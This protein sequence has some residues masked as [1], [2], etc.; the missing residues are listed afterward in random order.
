MQLQLALAFALFT[1]T[2]ADSSLS[3]LD[4]LKASNATLFAQFLQANPSILATYNSSS[5]QTVF[6]PSDAYFGSQSAIR[7]RD[8]PPQ[9]QQQLQY[10]YTNDLTNL[11]D[12][13]PPSSPGKVVHMGLNSPQVAG[14][15]QATVS[16]KLPAQNSTTRRRQNT[17]TVPSTGVQM[18]SGLGNS[19]NILK[20][21]IPYSN[22]VI[23]TLDG[24]FTLPTALSST[25]NSTGLSS[26][27][28]LLSQAN[29]TS[30]F[31]ASESITI[32]TP[33]NAAFAAAA[34]STANPSTLPN[35]LSNHV[36]P[37]FLGYLPSLV[38]GATYNT[39]AGDALTVTIKNG[40]YY[41]NDAKIVSS[42]TILSNGVAHV[43]DKVLVPSPS[44]V[45]TTSDRTL[46]NCYEQQGLK[47]LMH[48]A[49]TDRYIYISDSAKLDPAPVAFSD[50]SSFNPD[51]DIPI[52]TLGSDSYQYGPSFLKIAAAYEG[53]VV[54][55]LNRGANNLTNTIEAAKAAKA[56][57]PNL[58][59]I[60]L[61]NE[62]YIP[63][64]IS[65]PTNGTPTTLL[66]HTIVFAY[67]SF[68][69]APNTSTWT[70]LDEATSEST[71]QISIGTALNTSSLI[72][73]GNF[74]LPPSYGS[75]A[76]QLFSNENPAAIK[77]IRDF[78]HHNYP[79]AMDNTSTVPSPNLTTLMSH[80][81][82]VQ[83]VNLY[84]ADIEVTQKLGMEYV[85][86]ET[87]SV[88]GGGSPLISKTFGAALWVL[89]YTLRAT[90]TNI[91]HAHFHHGI[92]ESSFYVW[93]TPYGVTS[94]YYGGYAAASALAGGAYISVLDS[95]LTNY[96]GYVIYSSSSKPVRVV[97][98]N[99]DYYDGTA[100]RSNH[101]FVLQGIFGTEQVVA[102]RLTAESALA[103]QDEGDVVTVWGAGVWG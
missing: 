86:G 28:S 4:A 65:L 29:L 7:R 34:N 70:P 58:Y 102:R 67:L 12:L 85:F 66:K 48:V 33:N 79:Q 47:A 21:D 3:L 77:Y 2:Q 94:P 101:E 38:N 62:P 76:A 49:E 74:I 68:P 84:R 56:I 64:E 71:W 91:T 88:S 46:R 27:G 10:Q 52:T 95:G 42:N 82:I 53:N 11:E 39:L 72:Q 60:E 93:W 1:V 22:G 75:S 9:S 63:N 87:N 73:A 6:A 26:L 25:I 14:G 54:L 83:N 96:A 30:T 19:V 31:D 36:I 57:M 13:T 20:G 44:A 98:I 92:Y 51:L 90:S 5:V 55:G 15:S 23:H 32:F 43:I 80:V 78:S 97:L 100:K 40:V 103:R 59:A 8:N 18:L 37:N 69:I 61:G 81:N 50:E 17:G 24:F 89:D 45:V 99:T 16:N 41:V 35:L